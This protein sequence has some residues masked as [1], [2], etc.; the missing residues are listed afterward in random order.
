MQEKN[1]AFIKSHTRLWGMF[2]GRNGS[3]TVKSVATSL[4]EIAG[5]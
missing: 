5:N 3:R 2:I 4:I 1:E